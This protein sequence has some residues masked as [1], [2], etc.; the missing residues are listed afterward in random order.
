MGWYTTQAHQIPFDFALWYL[1]VLSWFFS[2]YTTC[3]SI[4]LIR[5]YITHNY[6]NKV[7]CFII[8]FWHL[9]TSSQTLTL[10]C[11]LI[12]HPDFFHQTY[13]LETYTLKYYIDPLGLACCAPGLQGSTRQRSRYRWYWVVS[14]SISMEI[15]FYFKVVTS[16]TSYQQNPISFCLHH[17][18]YNSSYIGPLS[19]LQ[20]LSGSRYRPFCGNTLVA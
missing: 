16:L 13:S 19:A 8:S 5:F 17:R 11:T 15:L 14:I 7:T 4:T 3:V 10:P 6:I 18:A 1:D 20:V 9:S 2:P 12:F